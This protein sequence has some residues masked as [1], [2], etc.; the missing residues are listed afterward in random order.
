[1][2]T[3]ARKELIEARNKAD[4]A[5]YTAEKVLRDL[6]DKVPAEMKSEVEDQVQP[7]CA[8]AMNSD[9][10]ERIRKA[11]EELD[12]RWCSRWAPQLTSR[13]P[14]AGASEAPERISRSRS[15]ARLR[16]RGRRRRRIPQRI[17]H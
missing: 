7:R 13:A 4:N 10:A 8:Q 6:G 5:V 17:V 2:K 12:A 11:T 14:T 16:R 3:C 9:D 1:M 15:E